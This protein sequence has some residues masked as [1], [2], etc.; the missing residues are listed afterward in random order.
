[1]ALLV[2]SRLLEVPPNADILAEENFSVLLQPVEDLLHVLLEES[3]GESLVEFDLLGVPLG[4][5]LPV[6][7][8]DLVDDGQDVTGSLL[9]VSGRIRGLRRRS[10]LL[11]GMVLYLVSV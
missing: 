11:E 2:S 6:V 10:W 8:E 5:Q 1:M 7:G 9:V 3:Q 4:L